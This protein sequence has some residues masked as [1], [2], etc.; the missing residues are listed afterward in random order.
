MPADGRTIFSCVAEVV[1]VSNGDAMKVAAIIVATAAA[2]VLWIHWPLPYETAYGHRES[3][4]EVR[5]V[6]GRLSLGATPAEV[7]RTIR[8]PRYRKLTVRDQGVTVWRVVTPSTIGATDWTITLEFG[9][10]G[11]AC[12]VVGTADDSSKPPAGVPTAPCAR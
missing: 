3:Q 6:V 7:E 9:A 2:A 11:L 1:V 10:K 5:D 4:R 12:V 8:H